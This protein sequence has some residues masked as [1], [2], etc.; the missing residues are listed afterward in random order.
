[1]DW[2]KSFVMH[3]KTP[4][5]Y[6]IAGPNG[7]GKTTFALEFLPHY[8][9]CFEFINPDLIAKGLAPLRPELA[10]MRAGRLVLERIRELTKLRKDFAFETTLAGQTYLR[11]IRRISEN[12]YRIAL[13]FVWIRNP[14]L[15]GYRIANRVCMGGHDVPEADRVR[16]FPRT[17]RNLSRYR[18]L[19]DAIMI[20]DNSGEKPMLVYEKAERGEMVHD[21]EAFGLIAKEVSI[22]KEA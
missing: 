3:G 22:V 20:F 6:I 18:Q 14:D 16:R 11:E 9:K 21:M 5:C 4:T 10:T 12:G 2:V 1:M 17:M 15:A 8:A 7:A 19:V 13:F